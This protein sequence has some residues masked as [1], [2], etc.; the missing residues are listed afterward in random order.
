MD[1]KVEEEVD[2]TETIKMK[3][4][5]PPLIYRIKSRTTKKKPIK[6]V[7]NKY[8]FVR[9]NAHTQAAHRT[10]I[11][12]HFQYHTNIPNMNVRVVCGGRKKSLRAIFGLS[13]ENE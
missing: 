1:T 8:S 2:K 3:K 10:Y 4:S 5:F 9:T 11:T 13:N 12:Y 7:F 6:H